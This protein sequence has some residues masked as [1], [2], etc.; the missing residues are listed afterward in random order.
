MVYWVDQYLACLVRMGAA[1]VAEAAAQ[2][3][4]LWA[5]LQVPGLRVVLVVGRQD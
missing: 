5:V 4:L 2:G 1:P 3:A